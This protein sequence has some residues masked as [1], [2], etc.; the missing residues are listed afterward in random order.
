MNFDKLR[1][2]M[3]MLSEKKVPG[4]AATV[5]VDGKNVFSYAS[6]FS[7]LESRT[8]MT[9]RELINIYSCSKITTVTAACPTFRARCF[10]AQRP[11]LRIHT[12]IS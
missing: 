8:P 2:F 11:A 6:G 1:A 3:D 5:Y 4:N 12:R 10:P 9:G 7:D